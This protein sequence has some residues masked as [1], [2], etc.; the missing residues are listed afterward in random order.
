MIIDMKIIGARSERQSI[1]FNFQ[2]GLTL[3]DPDGDVFADHAFPIRV[4]G[5]VAKSRQ[6]S[7]LQKIAEYANRDKL[8]KGFGVEMLIGW[9]VRVRIC[10]IDQSPFRNK[11]VSFLPLDTPS[12]RPPSHDDVWVNDSAAALYEI[13][14]DDDRDR[15]RDLNGFMI[16]TNVKYGAGPI[17]YPNGAIPADFYKRRISDNGGNPTPKQK[18]MF[19]R[20]IV[21]LRTSK[22]E[23]VTLET[24]GG[25]I[26]VPPVA[27][28]GAALYL[29]E[30]GFLKRVEDG[31]W[32]E[33]INA[34][35]MIE[36]WIKQNVPDEL[37]NID[38]EKHW[39]P[40]RSV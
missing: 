30:I 18:L 8:K 26:N 2:G 14:F 19:T 39:S 25:F 3:V 16:A 35:M 11:I 20:M 21:G 13:N 40:V 34:G 1:I 37:L 17:E 23:T 7:I 6:W 36:E 5:H 22:E 10:D 29:N 24:L 33:G 15:T 28:S 31:R 4:G 38:L 12:D 27:T 9:P 32:K